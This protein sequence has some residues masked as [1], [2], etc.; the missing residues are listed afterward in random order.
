MGTPPQNLCVWCGFNKVT[1][2]YTDKR[3]GPIADPKLV[4]EKEV[5]DLLE[6]MRR[7]SR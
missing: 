4:R 5:T 6:R 1:K 2:E 3:Y 7:P